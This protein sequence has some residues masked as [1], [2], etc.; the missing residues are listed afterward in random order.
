MEQGTEFEVKKREKAKEKKKKTSRS[1]LGSL[2]AKWNTKQSANEAESAATEVAPSPE[3]G[4]SDTTNTRSGAHT[5]TDNTGVVQENE[6]LTLSTLPTAHT[7]SCLEWGGVSDKVAV[8]D[9]DIAGEA[10]FRG[11]YDTYN[12]DAAFKR[13]LGTYACI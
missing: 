12:D 11:P 8:L 2:L 4:T 3:A 7:Q 9:G 1:S 10:L 13:V 6:M 5:D